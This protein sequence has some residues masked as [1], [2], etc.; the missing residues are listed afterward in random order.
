MKHCFLQ[1]LFASALLV[2]NVGV[3]SAAAIDDNEK[4]AI[5]WLERMGAALRYQNYE[6]IFTFIRGSTFDTVRI[7]HRAELG[8]ETERLFNLNGQVREVYRE[9][10]RV[11]CFHPADQAPHDLSEHEVQI[12]PFSAVFS[13]KVLTTQSSYRLSMIG[14]GRIAGR[15]AVALAI[16]PRSNDRY[17]YRLWLDKETGL[18]LQSHLIDRGRVK[19]IFQFASLE[20]G[21]PISEQ[22]LA[23]SIE[24]DTVSHHLSL[25]LKE[26]TDKP[27]WQVSWLPDGF[28]P[29]R[30]QGNRL[31]FSDGLATLSVFIE[32]DGKT[33]MPDLATTVGG[34]VVITR[35]MKNTGPQI[36]VVGDVPIQTA[37]RVAESVEPV[38]Y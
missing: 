27:V 8:K 38:I 15:S 37:E 11:L 6:G 25:D 2:M 26:H 12:G 31:L 21:K 33:S 3:A 28:R 20:I 32:S 23:S 9:D 36:T 16:S 24:G 35:R 17:G 30:I 4:E 1:R 5:V 19:E 10:D 22:S 29:V 18:M 7:V 13:E 34:T 14:E